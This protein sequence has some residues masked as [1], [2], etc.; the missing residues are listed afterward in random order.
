MEKGHYMFQLTGIICF[1]AYIVRRHAYVSDLCD[2]KKIIAYVIFKQ[3]NKWKIQ[4][5]KNKSNISAKK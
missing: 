4:R 1:N 2:R 3:Q 5:K